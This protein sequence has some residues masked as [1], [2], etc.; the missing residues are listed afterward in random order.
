MFVQE[1]RT[2]A[3]ECRGE[4]EREREGG[5]EVDVAPM[6]VFDCLYK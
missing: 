4:G 6:L 1:I 2:M 5:G 3:E